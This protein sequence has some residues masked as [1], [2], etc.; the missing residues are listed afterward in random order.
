MSGSMW[1]YWK[2]GWI[3]ALMERYA[4][5]LDEQNVVRYMYTYKSSV[6]ARHRILDVSFSATLT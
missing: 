3:D 4:V 1:L 6:E 2:Y 5:M